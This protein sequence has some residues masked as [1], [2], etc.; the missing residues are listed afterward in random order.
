MNQFQ[1][2]YYERLQS[3]NQ[4]RDDIK[5][6][7]LEEQ[8]VAVDK[9]WQRAPLVNHYLHPQD[10]QSWPDPWELISENTY[11]PVARGLGI[12]YTLHLLGIENV[13]MTEVS[14]E[15]G[16]DYILV[17]CDKYAMNYHPDTVLNNSLSQFTLKKQVDIS[18]LLAKIR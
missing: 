13:T 1:L 14:D 4:L 3:W 10:L 7:S 12:C 15:F 6:S 17:V 8:C 5:N 9:W 18:S 2:S 16:D 11:C